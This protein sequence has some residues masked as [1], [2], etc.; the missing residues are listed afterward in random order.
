[1]PLACL[2]IGTNNAAGVN[3]S[4]NIKQQR[5]E[6]ANPKFVTASKAP[7]DSKRRDEV[8]TNHTANF[9]TAS[10]TIIVRRRCH[11]EYCKI[12]ESSLV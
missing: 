5:K 7:K 2:L 11:V 4:R 1:M 10:W 8:G 3:E 12:N 6:Q 9:V